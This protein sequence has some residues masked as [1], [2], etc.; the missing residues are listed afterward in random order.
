M[1]DS[2]FNLANFMR[3]HL[4]TS[5]GAVKL[6][7]DILQKEESV[8][9]DRITGHGGL[10]TTPGCVQKYLA[11]AI[12]TPVTVMA[13]ATEGGPWGMAILAAYL[14]EGGRATESLPEYLNRVIFCD[15]KGNTLSPDQE[16]V[17]GYETFIQHYKDGLSIEKAA[18]EAAKW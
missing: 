4:Y 1:P 16:T 3:A 11:A 8:Q 13:T 10:F 17:A 18:I 5:L 12:N 15:M 9:I 14:K 7:M 2:K 6:G